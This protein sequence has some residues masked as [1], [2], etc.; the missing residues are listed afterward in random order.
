[1]IADLSESTMIEP[2][3]LA[4]ECARLMADLKCEDIVVLDVQG[5]SQVTQ[6]IVIANGTSERQMDSVAEDVG[7]LGSDHG[8]PVFRSARER[9]SNWIVID[10]VHVIVH[11]FEPNT[12]AFYDLESLWIDARRVP[13]RRNGAAAPRDDRS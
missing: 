11:L 4:V 3:S 1:M 10:F 7:E 2:G 5:L 9:A 8:H 12:R 6:F 13:W